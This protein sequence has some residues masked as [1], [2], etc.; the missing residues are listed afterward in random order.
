MGIAKKKKENLLQM[1]YLAKYGM[2][3][4]G[5][6]GSKQSDDRDLEITTISFW[7]KNKPQKPIKQLCSD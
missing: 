5:V 7:L 6:P 1:S 2:I 4:G 3:E